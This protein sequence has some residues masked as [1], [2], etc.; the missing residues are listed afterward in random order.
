VAE[1]TRTDVTVENGKVSGYR[2]RL[3]ISFKYETND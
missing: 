2:V 1:V 3:S